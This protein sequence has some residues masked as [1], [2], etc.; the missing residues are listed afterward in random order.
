MQILVD[1]EE[2]VPEDV[3]TESDKCVHGQLCPWFRLG[4]GFRL[5]F[6]LGLKLRFRLHVQVN[7]LIYVKNTQVELRTSQSFSY[8]PAKAALC[9]TNFT[10]DKSKMG[11]SNFG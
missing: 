9:M 7:T 5:G 1:F 11:K 2:G 8:F 3:A 6:R 4:F 10:T